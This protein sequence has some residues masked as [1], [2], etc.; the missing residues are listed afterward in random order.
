[1]HEFNGSAIRE[2]LFSLV[3]NWLNK[4]GKRNVLL[5]QVAG[6]HESGEQRPVLTA[7]FSG[8]LRGYR[9]WD[10]WLNLFCSRPPKRK[11]RVLLLAA[12]AV[13]WNSRKEQQPV[14]VNEWVRLARSQL[15]EPESR[16]VNAILR[17]VLRE[18]QDRLEAW[19]ADVQSWGIAWSHPD[20]LVERWL[21]QWGRDKTRALLEWN[22][23]VP[24]VFLRWTGPAPVPETLS[25][26]R[27]DGYYSLPESS[28]QWK[29][30]V[31]EGNAYIQDPATRIA[32]LLLNPQDNEDL[33]E[34]CAAPGGKSLMLAALRT[35]HPERAGVRP[36]TH[37]AVDLPG[38]KLETLQRNLNRYPVGARVQTWGADVLGL[39]AEALQ[40]AGFPRLWDTL[41]LDVP[42]SNTGVIARKPEVRYRL[43]PQDFD[44]LE[45][46]QGRMLEHAA[47]FVRPGG[48]LLYSTCSVEPEENECRIDQ[49]LR[50]HP[51]WQLLDGQSWTPVETGHDGGGAFLLKF[52]E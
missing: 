40:E 12:I 51:R 26:S 22:Q 37:L 41:F 1:M 32:V 50:N 21:G 10:E 44:Q 35:A 16:M 31:S 49:F 52:A 5:D 15:S 39:T 46:L 47:S 48:K 11:V 42:C 6:I 9:L 3:E 33:M 14:Q 20:W 18:G 43:A 25:A 7:W 19:Q 36:G 13:V 38:T 8:F 30:W 27:W 45:S 34:W 29:R 28:E 4:G 17:R 23:Q 24:P 2:Q